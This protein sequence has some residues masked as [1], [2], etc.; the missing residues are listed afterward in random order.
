ME[1][2]Y[3]KT[4]EMVLSVLDEIEHTN[5]EKV[6]GLKRNIDTIVKLM[7]WLELNLGL[8]D[9][10]KHLSKWILPFIDDHE[11]KQLKESTK[12]IWIIKGKDYNSWI[13]A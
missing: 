3:K 2:K 1:D 9:G 12:K 8:E 10:M 13:E 6:R 11:E 7:Y 4:R 5:P